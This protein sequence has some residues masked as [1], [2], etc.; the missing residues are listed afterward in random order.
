MIFLSPL[1]SAY[2]RTLT[3]ACRLDARATADSRQG[4]AC[5]VAARLPT[6]GSRLTTGTSA[7]SRHLDSCARWPGLTAAARLGAE[8]S[9][10]ATPHCGLGLAGAL[11]R[12]RSAA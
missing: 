11:L 2:T 8:A 6:A 5:V 7:L 3:N 12:R 1:R 10:Q 9:T 4:E